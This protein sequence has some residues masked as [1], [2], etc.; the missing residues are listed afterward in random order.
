MTIN[1]QEYKIVFTYFDNHNPNN[2]RLYN[3]ISTKH[4]TIEA[5]LNN[6]MK[7]K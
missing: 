2:F 1:V 4:Q 3:N 6:F 7:R 5:N